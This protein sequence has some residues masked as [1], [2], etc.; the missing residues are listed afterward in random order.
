[1]SKSPAARGLIRGL[2]FCLALLIGAAIVVGARMYFERREEANIQLDRPSIGGAFTLVDQDGKTVTDRDFRGKLLLVYFGYTFCP[3]VCPT[4]LQAMTLVMDELGDLAGT[5]VVPLFIT[6]DPQRD[7]PAVLK[8]YMGNFHPAF[9]ALTGTPEQIAQ[10]AKAY[11]VYYGKA[12]DGGDTD[13]LMDHSGFVYLMD[14]E[15]RYATHFRPNAPTDDV[16]KAIRQRL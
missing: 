10:A 6:I 1:M 4:E 3:D 9:H 13:Y 16:V 15:G 8:E 12:K 14:G 2:V 7:T 11:R 5:K